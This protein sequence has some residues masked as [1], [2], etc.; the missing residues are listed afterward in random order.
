VPIRA[1]LRVFYRGPEWRATR[2]RILARAGNKCEE[3]GV[4][5][6]TTVLRAYGW[7]TPAILPATVFMLGGTLYGHS[8][9]ELLWKC[10]GTTGIAEVRTGFIRESCR[11][12]H[13]VLSVAH[14][15][16]IPGDDRD[17]N[18][19][20]LCQWC[21]LRNDRMTHLRNAHITRATR[22]DRTRPLLAMEGAA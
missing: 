10:A 7:W 8:L 6:R 14:L 18:L 11:W 19:K 13:I 22:K 21:H 3:C 4:P 12:V 15:N 5:N 17:E 9:F 16:Q 20:A 1:D 2:A